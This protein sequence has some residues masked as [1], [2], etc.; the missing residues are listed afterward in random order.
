MGSR[1]GAARVVPSGGAGDG[2]LLN[3]LHL[4]AGGKPVVVYLSPKSFVEVRS[5][6]DLGGLLAKLDPRPSTAFAWML[7]R[8]DCP[9]PSVIKLRSVSQRRGWAPARRRKGRN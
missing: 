5:E 3:V 9:R 4:A 1:P 6:H 7:P 8:R 2:T